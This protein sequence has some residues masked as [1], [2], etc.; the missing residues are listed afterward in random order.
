V[1]SAFAGEILTSITSLSYGLQSVLQSL[2]F[3]EINKTVVFSLDLLLE[4]PKLNPTER[5]LIGFTAAGVSVRCFLG[6]NIELVCRHMDY[7]LFEGVRA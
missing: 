6:E 1:L 2:C 3:F 4:S 5:S 7:L